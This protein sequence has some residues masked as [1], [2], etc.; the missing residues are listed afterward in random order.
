MAINPRNPRFVSIYFVKILAV[1]IKVH[2]LTMWASKI[3]LCKINEKIFKLYH[4]KL[5]S[6]KKEG[7][8]PL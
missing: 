8:C 6:T 5:L 3:K 2:F 4:T 7:L 1:I